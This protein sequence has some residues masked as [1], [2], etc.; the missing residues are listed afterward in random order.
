LPCR[1]TI[2]GYGPGVVG[3]QTR[4][5]NSVGS[6]VVTVLSRAAGSLY[7]PETTVSAAASNEAHARTNQRKAEY[8][9]GIF[10]GHVMAVLLKW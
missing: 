1:N 7:S 6:D 10:S 4:A 8:G 9:V 2:N 3:R 5:H